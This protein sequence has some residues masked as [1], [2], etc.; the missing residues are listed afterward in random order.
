MRKTL[1]CVICLLLAVGLA[2]ALE[3]LQIATQPREYT[4]TRVVREAGEID[5]EHATL[6]NAEYKSGG[7]TTQADGSVIEADLGENREMPD[8]HIWAKKHLKQDTP[9]TVW[10]AK[11]G[12]EFT[13]ANSVSFTAEKNG[14]YWE[15]GIPA[16]AYRRIRMRVDGKMSLKSIVYSEALEE[17]TWVQEGLH[18]RRVLI[19]IPVLFVLLLLAVFLR[20]DRRFAGVCVRAWKG[21]TENGINTLL[22]LLTFAVAGAVGFF[23]ARWIFLGS[24]AAELTLPRTLFCGAV[25]LAVACLATFR[26]TLG[27]KPENLFVIFA[28]AAGCLF[29]FSF[30]IL[31]GWDE[32]YH[33]DEAI[34][35]SYL[36]EE[37][38]TIEEYSL[39][40]YSTDLDPDNMYL[41]AETREEWIAQQQAN[42]EKGVEM[43]QE[44]TLEWK[45]AFEFFPG[46]GLYLGRV[47]GLDFYR[48]FCMGKFFGLLTYV[49]CG[50]F[51]IRR[52]K[53]GKMIAAVCLLIPTAVFT[54]SVYSYD[55]GLTAFMT[56]GLAYFFAEWQEPDKPLTWWNAAVMLLSMAFGCLA[57]AV[58]FP[59]L[60]LLLMMPKGKFLGEA[61]P[62]EASPHRRRSAQPAAAGIRRIWYIG[63]VVL[64]ILALL[65]TFMIPLLGGQAENDDRG[66]SDVDAYGQVSYIL[67]NPFGYAGTLLSSLGSVFHPA[68]NAAV[69]TFLAYL[70]NGPYSGLLMGLLI[71]LALTDKKTSDLRLGRNIPVRLLGLLFL[72]GATCLIGTSMYIL[73]TPAG[74]DYI[75]GIQP[76]YLIPFI[77]PVLMLLGT[78]YLGGW[79]W[80]QE[81]PWQRQLFNGVAYALAV[82]VLYS[83]VY[84]IGI[85]RFIS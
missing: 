38:L 63:L 1:I 33:Y 60:F 32:G 30:N 7:V 52:L 48:Q 31:V 5:L 47:L 71:V 12:E 46:I 17:P 42:H 15:A 79:L 8:L 26:K 14:V 80:K 36:G 43:N 55:T 49:I 34:S 3:A 81:K 6:E 58:Y 69:L 62:A 77:F 11:D 66:G 41:S 75:A 70:G 57:K 64:V 53:T 13:D 19:M 65:S 51:A 35:H 10:Y 4:G 45:N 67:S 39:M 37:R 68:Q 22:H 16:G 40:Q 27:A 85:S 9:I 28:L 21:L 25:A 61:A 73:Y 84:A 56:L 59:M 74:A 23:A 24:L 72:F 44:K 29:I 76:R 82:F 54:A 20:V 18:I 2:F 83:N 50:Y 78:G